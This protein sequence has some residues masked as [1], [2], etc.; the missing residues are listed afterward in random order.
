[1]RCTTPTY[2]GQGLTASGLSLLFT[3]EGDWLTKAGSN[4]YLMGH[5]GTW[6]LKQ[7]LKLD[8]A[9]A[10]A[11]VQLQLH[12]P[13]RQQLHLHK[14]TRIQ[15][16]QERPQDYYN[17]HIAPLIAQPPPTPNTSQE[18]SWSDYWIVKDDCIIRVHKSGRRKTLL[19]NSTFN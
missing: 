7:G 14:A 2:L 16:L 18:T 5:S 12:K 6:Q 17:I 11:Q 19:S 9:A 10:T 13:T 4:L 15:L 1:M 8:P 3:T